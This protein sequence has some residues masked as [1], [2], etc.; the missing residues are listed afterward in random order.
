MEMPSFRLAA[1]TVGAIFTKGQLMPGIIIG[2]IVIALYLFSRRFLIE[3]NNKS[4][5]RLGKGKYAQAPAAR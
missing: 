4:A 1:S 3:E 2:P 5:Q